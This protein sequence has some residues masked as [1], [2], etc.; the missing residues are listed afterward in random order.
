[1]SDRAAPTPL[2]GVIATAAN[3]P[4]VF[5]GII[6]IT[7]MTS[8]DDEI[9]LVNLWALWGFLQA[10]A[11]QIGLVTASLDRRSWRDGS[12]MVRAASVA[13]FSGLVV[14]PFADRLF[15]G[16]ERWTIA[17]AVAAAAVETSSRPGPAPPNS[18][19]RPRTGSYA[20]ACE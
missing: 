7:A 17:V 1:M 15:P 4:I 10:L 9:A 2:L 18:T 14:F 6:A 5:V 3:F 16:H 13:V 19:T 8:G 20:I 12:V 11:G